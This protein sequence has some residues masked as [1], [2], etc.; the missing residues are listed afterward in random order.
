MLSNNKLILGTSAAAEFS[1]REFSV[2]TAGYSRN[3]AYLSTHRYCL[4]SLIL[5]V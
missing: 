4:L 3:E 1:I 2:S 5:M